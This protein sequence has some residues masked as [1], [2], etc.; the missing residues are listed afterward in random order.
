MHARTFFLALVAIATASGLAPAASAC[1]QCRPAFATLSRGEC[2]KA[3]RQFSSILRSNPRCAEAHL[4]M[5][6]GLLELRKYE[7]AGS[8]L[9]YA[10]ALNPNLAEAYFLKARISQELKNP[11]MAVA[12]ASSCIKLNPKF[13]PA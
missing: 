4:G 2:A 6:R 9:N 8:E 1:A 10:L 13:A 5:G 7:R 12:E 11:K 3:I